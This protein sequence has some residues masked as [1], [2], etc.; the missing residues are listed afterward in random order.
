MPEQNRN[1][2]EWAEFIWS[3]NGTYRA[4][5]ERIIAYFL[6]DVEVG[7]IGSKPL[8]EDEKEKFE[9]FFSDSVDILT[10]LQNLVRD[11]MCYGNSFASIMV[12]FR[13]FLTCPKCF[14]S[15]P[16][17]EIHQKPIYNFGW[18]NFK[19]TAKCPH[20]QY[21]GEWL[22]KDELAKRS[23][24]L[25]VKRWSPHE[26][27]IIHDQYTDDTAYVWRIPEEYKRQ[28]RQGSLYHLERAS[29]QVIKAIQNN[30]LFLFAPNAIFHMKEP[31]LGG[32]RNRGWGIS[33]TLTNFRQVWY[34]QVLRRYNE[35]IALDYVIPFRLITP[36]PRGGS[37]TAEGMGTDPLLSINMGDF[38]SQVRNMIR[39]RRRDPAS[40]A[41]LPFP[42][43]YQALGGDATQL[44]PR[45]LLDQ[46][47]EELLNAIGAPMELYRGTLTLQ[48]AP[49]ALRLFEST[50]RPTVHLMNSFLRWFVDE[51]CDILSWEKVR[52]T[53]RRVTFADD[54][55]RQMAMLQLMMGQVI[56]GKTGLEGLGL[57]WKD[58][59]RRIAEESRFQSQQQ[60]ELQEEMQQDAFGQ[61]IAKAQDPAMQA[62]GGVG[63][64]GQ[65][66]PPGGGGGGA[67]GG[68]A[69]AAGGAAGGAMGGGS[70][71]DQ[72]MQSRGP[73]AQVTPDDM[74][75][76]ADGLAQELMFRPPSQRRSELMALRR[77]DETLWHLVKGKMQGIRSDARSSGQ[78]QV[79]QQS[80]MQ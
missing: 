19:F 13:R 22:V 6:T 18:N 80:G 67:A 64:G 59:Q 32:F 34:V 27:E 28:I 49:V 14:F 46:G 24:E 61:Q 73:N 44:A 7:A 33:R 50:W 45:D 68:G 17:R 3:S 20:C 11:L 2:L 56:S 58:E 15:A 66:P 42:V 40:W 55:T 70:A 77:K 26:I 16:L 60:A 63:G 57:S 35:A 52:A 43:Q 12:P 51:V 54:M 69:G 9:S 62:G 8:G 53:M 29:L 4:A 79:L 23:T 41:T 48:A 72:Y 74:L 25:K 21:S 65:A 78:Q 75:E 39:R 47:T 36:V 30:Y 10:V 76:H 71:V 1:A 37:G 38:M 5:A 31:T